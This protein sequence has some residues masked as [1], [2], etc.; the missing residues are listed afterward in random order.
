MRYLLGCCALLIVQ[1]SVFA[2]AFSGDVLI[3][4][5][6]GRAGTYKIAEY[7]ADGALLQ[8]IDLESPTT[9]DQRLTPR[10][11]VVG[12][13]GKLHVFNEI[14][15]GPYLSSYDPVSETWSHMTHSGWSADSLDM[16]GG[17][18]TYGDQVFVTNANNGLIAFDLQA[19]TSTAFANDITAIDLT[20]GLDGKLWA[21]SYSTA[22]AFDPLTYAPLESVSF[23]DGPDPFGIAVDVDGTI[24]GAAMSGIVKFAPDGTLLD[25]LGLLPLSGIYDIDLAPDGSILI[26]DDYD[27][28][29]LTDTAFSTPAQIQTGGFN[30]TFVA[31]V[32]EPATLV[33]LVLAGGLIRRRR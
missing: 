6:Y 12:A 33:L 15:E 18:A 1:S 16:L 14:A 2:A 22:Y 30:S 29:W 4:S 13:N 27:S 8:L 21:H 17:I 26:G 32:P 3:Q 19:G 24:Y 9:P 10:D 5:R 20:L 25:S 7:T 23:D 11:L 31:F 28:A